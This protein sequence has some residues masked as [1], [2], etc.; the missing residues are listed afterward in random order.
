MALI[1]TPKEFICG[2]TLISHQFVL[3]AAHCL[4]D[5]YSPTIKHTNLIARLGEYNRSTE[6]ESLH[7]YEDFNVLKAYER[8]GFQMESFMNDIALLKLQRSVIY[9]TQIRPICIQLDKRSKSNSDGIQKFTVVG[10]GKTETGNVSDVLRTAEVYRMDKEHCNRTLWKPL[11]STQICA[12]THNFVDT[13]QGDSGGPLYSNVPDGGL[14]RQTQFGITSYGAD[15]CGGVGVYTDVMSHVDFIEETVMESD[16]TV[17]L[18]KMDLLDEG[19]LD[20]PKLSSR[21][22]SGPD[23]FPWLAQ[24]FMDSFLISY[25]ALISNSSYLHLCT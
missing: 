7:P 5:P 11:S 22:K 12:G 21:A 17:L 1:K 13:C 15:Q 4:Y 10:W 20:N 8:K 18:P 25:G 6:H 9:K 14:G 23:T 2:G 19:C 3:T 16:I 24:V